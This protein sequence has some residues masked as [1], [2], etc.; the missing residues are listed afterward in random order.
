MLQ[1]TVT[2]RVTVLLALGLSMVNRSSTRNASPWATQP[3]V[4]SDSAAAIATA[5]C[6]A[7]RRTALLRSCEACIVPLGTLAPPCR[8]HR[9]WPAAFGGDDEGRRGPPGH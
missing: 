3:D 9:T 6:P 7:Q 5:P 4:R 8:S 1:L 2:G